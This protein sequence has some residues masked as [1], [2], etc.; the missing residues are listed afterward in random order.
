MQILNVMRRTI[1]TKKI[2]S[3][4]FQSFIERF[5]FKSNNHFTKGPPFYNLADTCRPSAI[6]L[7]NKTP[8]T[9]ITITNN[10]APNIPNISVGSYVYR[11]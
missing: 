2:L 7:G 9:T 1:A 3:L 4:R 10:N 11:P 6:L 5:G 8:I